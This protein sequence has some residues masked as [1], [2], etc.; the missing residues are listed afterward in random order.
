MSRSKKRPLQQRLSRL[1]ALSLTLT[2]LRQAGFFVQYE[3]VAS[4]PQALPPYPEIEALCE[5]AWSS[6][7]GLLK[8]MARYRTVF[9][10]SFK[11]GDLNWAS[12][13]YS[14]FDTMATYTIVR[15]TAPARVLEIGSGSSTLVLNKALK[16]S[17]APGKITCID[18]APRYDIDNLGVEIHKRLLQVEDVSMVDEFKRG[19][20]LFIDSSHIML[21]GMDVDI[22]FNRMFPR[23]APGVMVH[24]HDI[25]LPDDYPQHWRG[26]WYSEQNALIGWLVSGYFEIVFPGYYVVSRMRDQVAQA[27]GGFSPLENIKSAG[28]L[29]LRRTHLGSG[30]SRRSSE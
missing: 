28:G 15:N 9:D 12:S 29:W 19:D 1:K 17:G 23:L 24:V 30:C 10:D 4:L 11:R 27:V 2:G 13:M 7:E 26:R 20:I 3:H 6:I 8:D 14:P 5:S 21:P 16:E 18:P 25:F 22:Q